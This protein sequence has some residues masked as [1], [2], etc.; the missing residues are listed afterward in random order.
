MG[1]VEM[2]LRQIPETFKSRGGYDTRRRRLIARESSIGGQ[3]FG[4]VP[5]GQR[6]EFF[7]LDE[8]TWVWHEGWKDATGKEVIVTTRY[9]LQGDKIIKMQDRQPHQLLSIAEARNLLV[10]A[11]EYTRR[12]KAELYAR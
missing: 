4:S 8:T 5:E 7:C 2:L 11:R 9:E 12:V 6:R 3:L 1:L 10:A